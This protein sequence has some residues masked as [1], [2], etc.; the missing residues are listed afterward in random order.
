MPTRLSQR[1]SSS[2]TSAD[3]VLALGVATIAVLCRAVLD[4]IAPGIAYLVVLLP[5]VVISGVFLGTLPGLVTAVGGLIAVGVLFVRTPLLA[6]LPL[7]S[8]QVDSLAYI[9]A[10]AAVLW[11]THTLRRSAANAARAEARLAEVFRQI[12]GA[13]AILEAPD[14]RLLLRSSQSDA[15]LAQ[16]AREVDHSS[17][18]GAYGGL[19]PDESPFAA[20]DYPIVRALKK[21]E[22]IRGEQVRYRRSDGQIA[23]LEVHAG[24]VRGAAGNIVA[25]VGMA[26]DVSDRVEAERRLR[27]SE[28]QYRATAE[29]L[30]A[31]IDAGTLGLWELN[32]D[33]Q[34]VQLDGTLAAMLGL[35]AVPVDLDRSD[36]LRH[37]H[38]DDQERASAVF[39]SALA[40]RGPYA[41]EI[42]MLTT[43]NEERWFGRAAPC[44]RTAKRWSVL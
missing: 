3:Y 43:Q 22:I 39:A 37:V 5:A 4:E 18:L 14:G 35:A 36:I 21:G 26:F 6:G 44:C 23:N 11:A 40:V 32:L 9:P 17:D 13:A 1:L 41:D 7:N 19:H 38:P 25:A 10:C 29:R 34:R 20:D 30:T 12:P 42:R 15:V 24:P 2:T 8:T 33:T 28:A 16:P 31:A 27:E